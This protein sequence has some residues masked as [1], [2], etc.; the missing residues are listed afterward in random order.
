MAKLPKGAKLSAIRREERAKRLSARE[1]FKVAKTASKKYARQL[2]QVAKQV[3]S[4]VEGL[5]GDPWRLKRALNEYATLLNPW[6]EAVV[7]KQIAEADQRDIRAWQGLAQEIG[8]ELRAEIPRT[9]F[10]ELMAEQVAL[11]T[12]L[13]LE[14]AK[15][16]HKLAE[17]A[18]LQGRRAPEIAKEIMRTGE[19]TKSRAMLIARTETSRT[20]TV[21]TETRAKHVGS[22]GYIW[23]T[24]GDTDV[25]KLHKDLEGT[26]HRWDDPP[27]AGENGERAHAGA[28][29]NCRCWA[30]PVLPDI[31]E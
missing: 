5:A 19:V 3:G 7:A 25:R 10:K 31:I 13:P 17:E 9:E 29:Y 26:F 14:A 2:S 22:I 1:R 28:I 20:A 11:I 15:R 30:E 8:Q 21:L 4:I 24:S 6:A 12:S 16:V 27:V 23:R 18:M